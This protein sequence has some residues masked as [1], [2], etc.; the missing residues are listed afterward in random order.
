MTPTTEVHV[1]KL[2]DM[3]VWAALPAVAITGIV[4]N[5]GRKGR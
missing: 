1:T 5:K 3:A 2:T 4:V